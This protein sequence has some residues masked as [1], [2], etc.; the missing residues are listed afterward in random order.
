MIKTAKT[1][2][3]HI[4]KLMML[5][6]YK[7]HKS[8][9]YIKY[10]RKLYKIQLDELQLTAICETLRKKQNSNFLVFGLGN[11]SVFW[12][13]SNQPGRTVFLEDDIEW[14]EKTVAFCPEIET[15]LVVYGTVRDQWQELINNPAKLMLDL[16]LEIQYTKWDVILVDG[17]AGYY[18]LSPGRMKS[19]YMASQLATHGTHVFF[20]DCNREIEKKYAQKYLETKH[21]IEY[22]GHEDLAHYEKTAYNPESMD[23]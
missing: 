20:H 16:P 11:D 3:K 21:L 18:P 17:P 4:L 14:Y 13:A 22:I 12:V 19:I 7:T 8:F 10:L 23:R 9:I 2:I 1:Y 5:K 15:Y 6:L